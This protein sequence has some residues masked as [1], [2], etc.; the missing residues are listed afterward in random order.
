MEGYSD[1]GWAFL[2]ILFFLLPLSGIAL[3]LKL[4][5]WFKANKLTS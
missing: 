4:V 1:T 2:S 5:Y 3:L